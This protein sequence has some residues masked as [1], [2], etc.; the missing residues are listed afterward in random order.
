MSP[1]KA[2]VN[3]ALDASGV[4]TAHEAV[5]FASVI[6]VHGLELPSVRVSCSPASGVVPEARVALRDVELKPTTAV[7]A[8][9]VVAATETVNGMDVLLAAVVA[10]PA[11]LAA[12]DVVPA[13]AVT[14]AI[15]HVATPVAPVVDWQVWLPRVNEMRRPPTGDP[16]PD[17]VSSAVRVAEPLCVAVVTPL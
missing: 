13:C 7:A 9:V 17:L 1:P 3:V 16:S 15:E 11:K 5:P 10:S 4:A 12:T 6:A 8:T 2:A 14:P